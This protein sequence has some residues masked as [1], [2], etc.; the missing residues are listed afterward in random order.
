M[1]IDGIIITTKSFGFI[2]STPPHLCIFEYSDAGP[3]GEIYDSI[4]FEAS[5]TKQFLTYS[6]YPTNYIFSDSKIKWGIRDF[7]VYIKKCDVSCIY[8]CKGPGP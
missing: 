6:T 2:L 8:S 7:E 4:K 3:S 1:E 5:H